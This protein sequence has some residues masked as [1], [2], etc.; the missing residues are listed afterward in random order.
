MRIAV[1]YHAFA[2]QGWEE[3]VGEFCEALQLSGLDKE[4]QDGLKLGVVTDEEDIWNR[5]PDF[6]EDRVPMDTAW[7]AEEG[8]EQHTLK[9]LGTTRSITRETSRRFS[10]ATP[11]ASPTVG[12]SRTPGAGP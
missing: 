5:L 2:V 11:K 4:M 8:W 6:V 10:T 1:Y 12:P 9:Q 3:I 7:R